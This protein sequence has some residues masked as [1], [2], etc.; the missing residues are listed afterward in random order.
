MIQQR[1]QILSSATLEISIKLKY[2][3]NILYLKVARSF[4]M[5]I[6]LFNEMLLLKKPKP[7]LVFK[8]IYNVNELC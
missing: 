3:L 6:D 5:Y 1:I 7:V 2:H 8:N 4:Y